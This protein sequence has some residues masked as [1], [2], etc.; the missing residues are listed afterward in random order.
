MRY[1]LCAVAIASEQQAD[2][3]Y[4]IPHQN[5]LN[6]QVTNSTSQPV[7]NG[8]IELGPSQEPS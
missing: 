1:M 4:R 6:F 2:M 3:A 5:F 7:G 8:L